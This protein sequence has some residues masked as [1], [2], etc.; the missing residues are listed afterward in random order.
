MTPRNHNA[1]IPFVAWHHHQIAEMLHRFRGNSEVHRTTGR[2]LRNL[3]GRTLMHIQ[4]N[5]RIS[6]YELSDHGRQRIAR[7]GVSGRD[8]KTAAFFVTEL[9]CHSLDAIDLAQ[10]F[11]CLLNN[12]LS[13]W[14]Y[15]CEVFTAP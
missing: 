9:L 14:C 4:R 3:H 12:R 15:S 2:H 11:P 13:C 8:V 1:A 10:N 5:F 7:L 6:V